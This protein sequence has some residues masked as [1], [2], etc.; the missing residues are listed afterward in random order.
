MPGTARD[1]ATSAWWKRVEPVKLTISG[2]LAMR[3]TADAK[4]K[5]L[6]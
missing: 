3:T 2:S 5:P 1:P 6:G 4:A